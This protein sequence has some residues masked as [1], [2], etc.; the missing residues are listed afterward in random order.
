M[1]VFQKLM[2]DHRISEQLFAEIERT[3]DK[4]TERRKQLF[5]ELRAGLEAHEIS[6]EEILYPETLLSG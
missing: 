5:R 4:E 3:S 2:H 6:E 1:N